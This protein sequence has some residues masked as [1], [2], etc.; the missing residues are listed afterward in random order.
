MLLQCPGNTKKASELNGLPLSECR[1]ACSQLGSLEKDT[2]PTPARII[3]KK[4]TLLQSQGR[5]GRCSTAAASYLGQPAISNQRKRCAA[6]QT[7]CSTCCASRSQQPANPARKPACPNNLKKIPDLPQSYPYM[8][9]CPLWTRPT[10]SKLTK[11]VGVN[12]QSGAHCEP[13]ALLPPTAAAMLAAAAAASSCCRAPPPARS[14]RPRGRSARILQ[15]QP[16]NRVVR[17]Q[18][19]TPGTGIGSRHA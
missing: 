9:L 3:H 12:Q 18:Q 2:Q 17:N 19:P 6:Q 4:Y 1:Q 11:D 14:V 5:T 13:C 8:N 15:K 10:S 7:T 16:T